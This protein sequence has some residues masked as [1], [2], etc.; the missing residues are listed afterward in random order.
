MSETNEE[1]LIPINGIYLTPAERFKLNR[2][3]DK[4]FN[5]FTDKNQA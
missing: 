1:Y 2:E 3:L 4:V 5:D